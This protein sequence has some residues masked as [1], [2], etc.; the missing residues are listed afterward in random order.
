VQT[1]RV[2]AKYRVTEKLSVRSGFAYERYNEKDWARDPMQAFMGNYDS[3]TPGGA[4]VTQG[5]QSVW[6]GATRPNYER[7]LRAAP[8]TIQLGWKHSRVARSYSRGR[9]GP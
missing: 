8:G 7:H 6:L 3:T 4:P 2:I 1:V 5:V 9:A